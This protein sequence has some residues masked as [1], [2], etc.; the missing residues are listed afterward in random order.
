MSETNVFNLSEM[1]SVALS[2]VYI[3]AKP[4]K[5]PPRSSGNRSCTSSCKNDSNC[6]NNEKCC[7]NGCGLYCTAPYTV[8][9][10]QC[11]NPKNIPLSAE[12]CSHD[13]Q[14]PATKKCS[15][16]VALSCVCI[17]AKPGKCPPRSSGNRSCT[18]S[19]K[20]DS[21]CPNNEKCCSNGCGLY[22]TAPYTGMCY[23]FGQLLITLSM[24]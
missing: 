22:C 24:F 17:T 12:S 6:P 7:S 11:P 3:T 18:S 20:N 13:G 16:S 8:K 15:F 10:G 2:C 23:C 4:G 14:C 1:F 9:P 21:N 5:C 19:C